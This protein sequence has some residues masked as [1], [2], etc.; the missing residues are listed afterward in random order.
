M[1]D[2]P[3]VRRGQLNSKQWKLRRALVLERD[4][5]ICWLCQRPGADTVDHVT[6]RFHGGTDDL[7]NLRAAHNACNSARRE[8]A[9][10]VASPTRAW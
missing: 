1:G 7:A 9:P 8:R 2:G 5:A 4:G 3:G 10:A 6:P